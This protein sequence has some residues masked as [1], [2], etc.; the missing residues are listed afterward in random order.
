[1]Q[2]AWVGGTPAKKGYF[3]PPI[4]SFE[5]AGKPSSA[6]STNRPSY[7]SDSRPGSRASENPARHG[8]N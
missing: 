6:A 5:G 7:A 4:H 3:L 1:M 8:I 2:K